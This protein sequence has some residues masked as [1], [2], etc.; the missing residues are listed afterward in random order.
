M[1]DLSSLPPSQTL[2][3][4]KEAQCEDQEEMM[5]CC[6]TV[7]QLVVALP[8]QVLCSCFLCLFGSGMSMWD[9]KEPIRDTEQSG[10]QSSNPVHSA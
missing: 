8:R 5:V 3:L 9:G 1:C 7:S 2:K 6:R 10:R 4:E